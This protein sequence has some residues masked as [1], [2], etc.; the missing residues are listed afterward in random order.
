[1][2]RDQRFLRS[3]CPRSGF[4]ETVRLPDSPILV[5]IL[6]TIMNAIMCTRLKPHPYIHDNRLSIPT[7]QICPSGKCPHLFA[8]FSP[9]RFSQKHRP[10]PDID[11]DDPSQYGYVI[12]LKVP[13]FPDYCLIAI[14]CSEQCIGS[15]SLT[16]HGGWT[17]SY[18][19]KG[20]ADPISCISNYEVCQ[21]LSH[22]MIFPAKLPEKAW[23]PNVW[24]TR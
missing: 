16:D 24:K 2:H 15:L 20:K 12:E 19:C 8:M 3:F 11:V 18:K 23:S 7:T 14:Q 22:F 6:L 21:I 13:T 4:L 17:S 10:M 9:W 1:M 5:E